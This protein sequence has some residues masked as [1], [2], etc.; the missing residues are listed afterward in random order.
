MFKRAGIKEGI[1][2]RLKNL[3]AEANH[4]SVILERLKL[5][6]KFTTDRITTEQPRNKEKKPWKGQPF[7]LL[8]NRAA[9][10]VITAC[11]MLCLILLLIPVTVLGIPGFQRLIEL[12]S[13]NIVNYLQ[14]VML[15]SEDE[16]IKLE[17][18]AA[19]SDEDQVVVVLTLQDLTGD[20]LDNTTDLESYYMDK[21]VGHHSQLLN[22]DESTRTA[23]FQVIGS[24]GK[25]LGGE[26][27]T[28]RLMTLH[29][30]K[31]ENEMLKLNIPCQ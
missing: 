13:P 7:G 25:T 8:T 2:G 14:P 21:L 6:D 17:V 5:N 11:I 24:G 10:P 4:E 28:L 27:I 23:M 31:N 15:S 19:V 26:K 1:N 20:R 9:R 30:K 16:G 12:L 29:S 18:V 3:K 22:Y